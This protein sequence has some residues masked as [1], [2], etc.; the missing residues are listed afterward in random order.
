[1]QMLVIADDMTGAADAAAALVGPQG[2]AEV[3]CSA[4]VVPESQSGVIAV[5]LDTRRM[6]ASA[7][8]TTVAALAASPIAQQFEIFKKIDPTLRGHIAV[9]LDALARARNVGGTVNVLYVITPAHP[10]LGRQVIDGRLH[11]RGEPVASIRPLM[12]DLQARG[13][14]CVKIPAGA[15]PSRDSDG[16]VA[17]LCDASTVEDLQ[18]IVRA[19]RNASTSIVWVGS[20][21]LAQAIQALD[22]GCTSGSVAS[23]PASG[24]GVGGA[25]GTGNIAFL[26]GSFSSVA[27][28]QV[29]A[30]KADGVAC[31]ELGS[32]TDDAALGSMCDAVRRAG[33][34]GDVVIC[35]DPSSEVRPEHADVL[36]CSLARAALACLH[37]LSALV[38]CGGDTARAVFESMGVARLTIRRSTES[39]ATCALLEEMPRLRLV[40]KAGAFGDEQQLV[41]LR[42]RLSSFAERDSV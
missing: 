8:A 26:V 2:C 19:A 33:G 29:R 23:L 16:R 30:L 42:R 17:W 41:R 39:G 35:I 31:F 14:H 24:C 6:D 32:R 15:R 12:R 25:N 13:F 21:G 9:E 40:L 20:A 4:S 18:H 34:Q 28:S 11:V 7:A 38:I 5:D 3:L 1:M 27:R 10:K 37:D 36:A 22:E